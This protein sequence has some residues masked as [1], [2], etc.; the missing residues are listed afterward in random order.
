MFPVHHSTSY[1]DCTEPLDNQSFPSNLDSESSIIIV[2]RKLLYA[3]IFYTRTIPIW[4][5]THY[6]NVNPSC[7][8]AFAS[9]CVFPC[10]CLW[11]QNSNLEPSKPASTR[12]AFHHY[13]YIPPQTLPL[14]IQ[15]VIISRFRWWVWAARTV[16]D[17]PVIT[18]DRSIVFSKY[19]RWC[20]TRLSSVFVEV[21]KIR[22]HCMK[23]SDLCQINCT[24]RTLSRDCICDCFQVN[25]CVVHVRC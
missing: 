17:P 3:P 15:D 18:T 22:V 25:D 19:G 4:T 7:W 1:F 10:K 12:S 9:L 6:N 13:R 16:C 8:R 11:S 24:A 20:C 23:F 2:S 14:V 5:P 21:W